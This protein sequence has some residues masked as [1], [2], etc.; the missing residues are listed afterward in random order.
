MRR[1]FQPLAHGNQL[2]SSL[3]GASFE[4]W[5]SHLEVVHLPLGAAI[6]EA[7]GEIAHVYFPTTAIAS[8]MYVMEDGASAEIAVVGNDGMVGVS[9]FMGGI[10]TPS[11]AV[12]QSAGHSYRVAMGR[13]T[14]LLEQD[15][16]MQR[17]VLRYTQA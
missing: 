5:K 9:V 6:Y 4:R 12:V 17:L 3:P 8:L 11:R 7:G 10:T 15:S 1:H 13:F 16:I 14:A 2:L